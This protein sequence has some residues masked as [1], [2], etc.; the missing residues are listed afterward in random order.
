MIMIARCATCRSRF[1]QRKPVLRS[2]YCPQSRCPRCC[3]RRS[4]ALLDRSARDFRIRLG[5]DA[6]HERL[7]PRSGKGATTSGRGCRGISL[8]EVP[9]TR[10]L[11]ARSSGCR[12]GDDHPGGTAPERQGPGDLRDHRAPC[13]RAPLCGRQAAYELGDPT[14]AGKSHGEVA[15]H[16]KRGF[17]AVFTSRWGTSLLHTG[18][19]HACSS[20]AVHTATP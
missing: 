17:L 7:A 2:W 1:L 10:S 13:A 18:D 16:L 19:A 6:S 12:T 11:R 20:T 15:T 3:L 4:P 8:Q 9:R 14:T 5:V